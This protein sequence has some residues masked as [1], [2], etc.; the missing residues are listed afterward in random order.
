LSNLE[1]FE[2][3]NS[4][5]DAAAYFVLQYWETFPRGGTPPTYPILSEVRGNQAVVVIGHDSSYPSLSVLCGRD[6]NSWVGNK[7]VHGVPGFDYSCSQPSSV[8]IYFWETVTPETNPVMVLCQGEERKAE[9][10]DGHVYYALWK[11][12]N[13][14]PQ[15]KPGEFCIHRDKG[16]IWDAALQRPWLRNRLV[17]PADFAL[18]HQ[19]YH[20][21]EM[22]EDSWANDILRI[23]CSS[24]EEKLD[25]V[26][27]LIEGVTDFREQKNY[28]YS[29]GAGPLEDMMS[30]WLLD[31]IKDEISD[32][33]LLT[34]LSC[35]RIDFEP[36]ELQQRFRRLVRPYLSLVQDT[37]LDIQR[38]ELD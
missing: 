3:F 36:A 28:L 34:A 2:A 11:L 27:C 31:E 17:T 35:V 4:L 22:E 33:R 15:W 5:E 38:T 20:S 12:K 8:V 25:I 7:L 16:L 9:V 21:K 29:L 18:A 30:N 10:I 24:G 19:R 1:Y 13:G 26:R 23:Y 6:T 14:T 37:Y 32:P